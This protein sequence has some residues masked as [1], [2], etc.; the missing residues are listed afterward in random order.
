MT[1]ESQLLLATTR[2]AVTGSKVTLDLNVDWNAFLKLARQHNLCGLAYDGLKKSDAD[3]QTVPD[4]ILDVLHNDYF[5]AICQSVRMDALRSNLEKGLQ[6]RQVPHIFLKGAVLKFNYPSSALRTMGDLDVLA[7]IEDYPAIDDLAE[8]LGGVHHDGDG[9]HRIFQFPGGLKV[10]FHPNLLHP[11]S[12]VGTQIN[13]GWQYAKPF[14]GYSMELTEE[15]FYLHIICHMAGHFAAAGVG[16]RLLLDIWVFQNLRKEPIDRAF[17][18]QE[19]ERCGLLEFTQNVEA[20]AQMW[21]GDGEGSP[22]LEELGEYV[23]SSGIYGTHDQLMLNAVSLADGSSISA[24]MKRAFYSRQEMEGRFPWLK[25][26]PWLLPIAWCIRAV[27]VLFKRTGLLKT[28]IE[29]TSAV[30]KDAASQQRELLKSFGISR[31]QK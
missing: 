29:D 25:G 18:E 2:I 17:V 26:R 14:E 12:P 4:A 15:G 16:I 10:E 24:F 8:E 1:P 30:S 3:L 7:R 9:N 27:R 11:D 21:F 22:L 23:I 5:Y 28:W 20:L 31:E 13:P 19:L 6:Q